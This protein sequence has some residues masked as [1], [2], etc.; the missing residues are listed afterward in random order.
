MHEL[1]VHDLELA[2]RC[3]VPEDGGPGGVKRFGLHVFV[4]VGRGHRAHP[5]VPAL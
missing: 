3:V 2:G 5:V 4:E 1:R